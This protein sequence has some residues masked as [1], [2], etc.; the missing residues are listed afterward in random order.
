MLHRLVELVGI[1][2]APVYD[3]ECFQKTVEV[4]C[5]EGFRAVHEIYN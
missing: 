5:R 4:L 2:T 3:D 1:P